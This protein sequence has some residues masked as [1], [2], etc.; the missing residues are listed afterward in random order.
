LAIEPI[1][2]IFG[3][4]SDRNVFD[5]MRLPDGQIAHYSYALIARRAN[6]SQPDGIDLDPKS[7]AFSRAVPPR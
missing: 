1:A 3:G 4:A 2:M 5:L 7:K 6:L